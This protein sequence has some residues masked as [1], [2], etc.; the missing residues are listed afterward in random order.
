MSATLGS[1]ENMVDMANTSSKSEVV[2]IV[3]TKLSYR[4]SWW[5]ETSTALVVVLSFWR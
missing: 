4:L 5:M 3:A 1:L 2:V